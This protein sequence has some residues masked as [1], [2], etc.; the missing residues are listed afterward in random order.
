MRI[1][2][3]GTY[4]IRTHPRV[5][6][7]IEGFRS[8]GDTVEEANAPLGIGTAERVNMLKA[9]WLAG[10][11]I[12][13]L[14]RRWLTLI[15]RSRG[16]AA[17]DAVVIGYMGHFDVLLARLLFRDEIIVLDHLVSASDTALDRGEGAAWK[18]WLLRRLD[19]AACRAADI[20]VVDTDQHRALVP[21][22]LRARALVVPV[23]APERWFTP[24]RRPD[25]APMRVV[26]FGLYTPLQ[27]APTI[28]HALK[29]V[30]ERGARIEV[31]MIGSGQDFDATRESAGA[32]PN[33]RWREWVAAES[34]PEV[35]ASHHVCLGI[36]GS[37]PKSLRVVPNKVFQGAAAGCAIITSDTVPQRRALGDSAIFVPPS[38]PFALADALD[39]LAGDPQERRRY[40]RA[41][42]EAAE[43]YFRPHAVVTGLRSALHEATSGRVS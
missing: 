25:D 27:G 5:E 6:V 33:V 36:F 10:K 8:Q 14:G 32:L 42:R 4:D 19:R 40:Q 30:A 12:W 35:V 34:L 39:R 16:I 37:G 3:F 24:D 18:Q 20:V 7:L 29:L 9:P 13:T 22:E 28:G 11:L 31:T 26:F 43:A 41:A 21:A 1:L 38:D 15:R 17:P 23:G 2:F